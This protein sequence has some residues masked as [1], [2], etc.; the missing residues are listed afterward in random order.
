V[1]AVQ[2]PNTQVQ[3][4]NDILT[5]ATKKMTISGGLRW[6]GRRRGRVQIDGRDKNERR[7]LQFQIIHNGDGFSKKS[8]RSTKKN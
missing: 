7:V 8:S 2:E 1:D 3:G 4:P 5:V 6:I